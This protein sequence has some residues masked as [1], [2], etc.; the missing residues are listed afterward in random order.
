M[1]FLT[2]LHMWVGTPRRLVIQTALFIDMDFYLSLRWWRG[3]PGG[4]P[5]VALLLVLGCQFPWV[6]LTLFILLALFIFITLF[7]LLLMLILFLILLTLF[8]LLTLIMILCLIMILLSLLIV[9]MM[10]VLKVLKKL[11]CKV[12]YLINLII[13][14]W[15]RQRMGVAIL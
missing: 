10:L 6:L 12:F 11:L 13:L 5:L 14:R 9:G 8:I 1:S 2:N 3:I 15:E 4:P 7:I